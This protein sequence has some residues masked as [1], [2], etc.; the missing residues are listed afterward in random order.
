MVEGHSWKSILRHSQLSLGFTPA[1]LR[2]KLR[3]TNQGRDETAYS[4]ITHFNWLRD[5][6][7]VGESAAHDLVLSHLNCP[8]LRL[9]GDCLE[10]MLNTG[11]FPQGTPIEAIPFDTISALLSSR[12]ILSEY[13]C[14]PS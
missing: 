3:E 12:P 4:F 9:F 14:H 1:A 2:A 11:T 6:G 13:P 7:G 8:T 5:E 10:P